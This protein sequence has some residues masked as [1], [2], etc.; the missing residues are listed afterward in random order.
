TPVDGHRRQDR[1][2]SSL[3]RSV[4][5]AAF[6]AAR[7]YAADRGSHGDRGA[8]ALLRRTAG[9]NLAAV[10]GGKGRAAA[11]SPGGNSAG[12]C[13]RSSGRRSAERPAYRGAAD[14]EKL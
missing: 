6:A 7:R 8:V 13:A 1:R 4:C 2:G 10:D 3:L 14:R 9:G 11:R 12:P 5:V